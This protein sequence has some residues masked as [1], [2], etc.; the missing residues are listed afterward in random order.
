MIWSFGQ[1]TKRFSE[2]YSRAL[3]QDRSEL[4]VAAALSLS[5]PNTTTRGF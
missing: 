2:I 3:S 5:S 4:P 1:A